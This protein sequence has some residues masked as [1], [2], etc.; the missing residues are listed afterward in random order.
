MTDGRSAGL[1]SA[2][3]VRRATAIGAVLVAVG[4]GVFGVLLDAVREG[5]DI[6]RID[7]PVLAWLVAHRGQGANALF[8]GL[9]TVFGPVV[10][11]LLVA[12]G[13]LAWAL[14]SRERWRPALLVGSMAASALLST[15][16]KVII[17]RPRPP[18]ASMLVPGGETTPSFPSGHTIGAAT[19]FLVAGYL[20]ASRRPTP[21]RVVGWSIAAA[22]GVLVVGL[23]RLYLGYHFATDVLAAVALAVAVLGI[24]AIVDQRHRSAASTRQCP[25]ADSNCQPTD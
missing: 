15:V 11:P 3:S 18:I 16:L 14:V 25:R 8:S 12:V 17:A 19:L 10:L 24:A 7:E 4:V 2:A 13:C 6:A 9:A 23:S 21:A 1:T 20:V 22:L 5:D